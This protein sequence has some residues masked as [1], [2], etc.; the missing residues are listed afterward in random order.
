MRLSVKFDVRT[1]LRKGKTE[2]RMK[3]RKGQNACFASLEKEKYL[4]SLE[5][6]KYL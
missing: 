2:S 6:V 3:T 4:N 5:K 1:R